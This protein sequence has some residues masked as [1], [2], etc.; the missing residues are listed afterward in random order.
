MDYT[1]EC[2]GCHELTTDPYWW[3]GDFLQVSNTQP[4][5]GEERPYCMSCNAKIEEIVSDLD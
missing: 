5:P 3:D 1:K 4:E 2:T